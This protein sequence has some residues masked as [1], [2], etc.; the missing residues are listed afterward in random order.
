MREDLPLVSFTLLVQLALGAAAL[1]AMAP[2]RVDGAGLLELRLLYVASA[3]LVF[4]SGT[5]VLHL[6]VKTGA[7][8]ALRNLRTSWLSREVLFTGLFTTLTL[9][10]TV[11]AVLGGGGPVSGA[12]AGAD[13]L[14]LVTLTG[15]AAV[16]TMSRLYQATIRPPWSTL[17]TP[18]SFFASAVILGAALGAPLVAAGDLPSEAA[19]LLL[20][21]I[22]LTAAAGVTASLAASALF[23]S[24]LQEHRLPMAA[25]LLLTLGGLGL[26][27]IGWYAGLPA[28]VAAG[29][30]LLAAGE[31]L[32]RIRFFALGSGYVTF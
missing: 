32:A 11:L 29:A 26:L 24:E 1:A 21:D 28:L 18:I 20:R 19:A 8:R 13:L 30:V 15:L 10:A 3:A 5:S 7:L 14:W 25:R 6:G 16:F 9:A 12:L 17:Y 27:T 2:L 22:V 4:A 31:L 23:A